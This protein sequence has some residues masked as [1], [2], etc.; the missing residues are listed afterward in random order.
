MTPHQTVSA[1]KSLLRIAGCFLGIYLGSWIWIAWFLT[2]A[3]ILGVVEE[4]V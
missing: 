1:F 4:L 2:V 3:E